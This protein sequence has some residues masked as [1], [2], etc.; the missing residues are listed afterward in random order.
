MSTVPRRGIR[1]RP[2]A[3]GNSAD[4]LFRAGDYGSD[5]PEPKPSQ[6][7]A[8]AEASYQARHLALVNRL[9]LNAPEHTNSGE[10]PESWLPLLFGDALPDGLGLR[11]DTL[12]SHAKLPLLELQTPVAGDPAL[13]L[14]TEVRPGSHHWLLTTMPGPALLEGT[15][16]R[17]AA[18]VWL[19]G[20]VLSLLAA[21]LALYL[22]RHMAR[23]QQR[24]HTLM[25]QTNRITRSLRNLELEKSVLRRALHDAEA[26]SRDLI[27]ISGGLT[28]ELD[29]NGIIGFMSDQCA[30]WLGQAPSDLAGTAFELLIRPADRENFRRTLHEAARGTRTQRLDAHLITTSG[31]DP[32][33]PASVRIRPVRTDN[34]TLTGF[35]VSAT[36][37]SPAA[38]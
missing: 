30:D 19:A 20:I 6:A 7:R 2:L 28:S 9:L 32:S 27:A 1:S 17:V 10:S 13:A 8:V 31:D 24:M 29:G 4:L 38:G 35:R 14:R 11:I 3:L 18:Q 16:R 25:Q 33:L 12:Q 15:A 22:C 23:Q 26:R 21:A 34:G 37:V 36:P 5:R